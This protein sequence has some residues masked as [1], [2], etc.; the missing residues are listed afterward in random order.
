MTNE[1][2]PFASMFREDLLREALEGYISFTPGSS[3][4]HLNASSASSSSSDPSSEL[5]KLSSSLPSSHQPALG[6]LRKNGHS[7]STAKKKQEG[8]EEDDTPK[9]KVIEYS[10]PAHN[11]PISSSSWISLINDIVSHERHSFFRPTTNQQP[12]IISLDCAFNSIQMG[13]DEEL[14]DLAWRIDSALVLIDSIKDKADAVVNYLTQGKTKKFVALHVRAEQDW[15]EHCVRWDDGDTRN[16]CMTNTNVLSN[17][18]QIQKIPFGTTLY[19]A[20]GYTFEFMAKSS[21]FTDLLMNYNVVTKETVLAEIENSR[22]DEERRKSSSI[23]SW[24]SSSSSAD[25]LFA[26]VSSN[27]LAANRELFASLD[28]YVCEH[29]DTFVGNSVSTFSAFIELKRNRKD[30]TRSFHYN[31]GA[32][33]ASFLM[34]ASA[35]NA[36]G[37]VVADREQGKRLK[38]IFS[39]HISS[40]SSIGSSAGSVSDEFLQLKAAV[41][42]AEKYTTLDPHCILSIDYDDL[43]EA[44]ATVASEMIGWL[45]DNNVVVIKHTPSWVARMRNNEMLSSQPITAASAHHLIASFLRIDIPILGFLDN[46]VL[47]TDADVVFDR[48]EVTSLEESIA[49]GEQQRLPKY[50]SSMVSLGHGGSSSMILYNLKGTR[51]TYDA[52]LAHSFLPQ[53]VMPK[54]GKELYSYGKYGSGV[55]GAYES[56]YHGIN[57]PLIS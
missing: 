32:I 42:Y 40:S 24:K 35:N 55:K 54:E 12:I 30:S 4:S 48:T 13:G 31:G 2:I 26:D 44:A 15:V 19:I 5:A 14:I 52:F 41:I 38:W 18:L 43:N 57:S 46:Y 29:S 22:R 51:R 37:V 7:S 9:G 34:P 25:L 17:V 53:Y 33:H 20:G 27:N 11:H 50:L 21:I 1:I 8:K 28:Y 3:L 36:E 56:F 16:N 39:L 47:Y 6:G 49:A 10:L 23:L 45:R